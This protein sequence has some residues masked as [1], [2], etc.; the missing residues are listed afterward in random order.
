MS[1]VLLLT[2]KIGMVVSCNDDGE[3]EHICHGGIFEHAAPASSAQVRPDFELACLREEHSRS[4]ARSIIKGSAIFGGESVQPSV[5]G[6]CGRR[7][8]GKRL[9]PMYLHGC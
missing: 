8:R 2:T 3:Q 5:L 6:L 4:C 1:V 9:E 7:R